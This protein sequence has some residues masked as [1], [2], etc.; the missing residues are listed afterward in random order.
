MRYYG[1][2]PRLRMRGCV[3]EGARAL[4]LLS[5]PRGS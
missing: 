4:A 1:A 3:E 2:P 5:G